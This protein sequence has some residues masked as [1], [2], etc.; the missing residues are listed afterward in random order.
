MNQSRIINLD[1]IYK[2][3]SKQ[4]QAHASLM[5]YLLYGGAMGGGKSVFGCME[6]LMLS[7]EYP[8]NVGLIGRWELSSLKRTTLVEFFRFCPAELIKH[9]SKAEGKIELINGSVIYYMG[10]KPSSGVNL[11][12]RLKSLALGW[13]FVDEATEVP[14]E[15]FDILKTRLRLRLPDGTYPRYRGLLASNPEPGWVRSTFIEQ[16]LDGHVFIPA[17]P[18]DNPFLSPDYVTE[19]EKTLPPE[20]IQ[21]YLKGNWDVIIGSN[22]IFPYSLIKAAVDRELERSSPRESGIDVARFGGD[23]NVMANRE[24]PVVDIAYTSR[25][26]DTMKTTGELALELDKFKP[27]HA[28]VDSVGV[29]AGVYDRLKEQGYPVLEVVG[30]GSPRDRERFLN[31]RAENH[32]GFRERLESGNI[33]LPDRQML[34]SQLAGIKYTIQSDRR[35][36]VESKE[37][38]KKRGMSSPDEADGVINA[39]AEGLVQDIFSASTHKTFAQLGIQ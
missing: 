16:S 32:W 19:L 36:K 13:F 29:G 11:I 8:G 18:E 31:V 7:L 20:L 2:P 6:G 25:F 37:D 23:M 38:M 15:I 5:R 33:D 34:I 35:V 21:K 26:Q 17:L 24:G 12:E 10:F 1:E 30:G 9:H 22:Y 28:K 14:K 39:F 4:R 3:H 27:K